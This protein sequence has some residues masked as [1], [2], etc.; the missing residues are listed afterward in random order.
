MMAQEIFRSFGGQ[1][2]LLQ[3]FPI[4]FTKIFGG[5][6][7]HD[8][9]RHIDGPASSFLLG[10]GMIESER[11]EVFFL[12]DGVVRGKL[13]VLEGGEKIDFFVEMFGLVFFFVEEFEGFGGVL[14]GKVGWFIHRLS[15]RRFYDLF[16]LYKTVMILSSIIYILLL[17]LISPYYIFCHSFYF[18]HGIPIVRNHPTSSRS[19]ASPISSHPPLLT[20]ITSASKLSFSTILPI[21]KKILP[22]NPHSPAKSFPWK[23][24]RLKA[25]RKRENAEEKRTQLE[26]RNLPPTPLFYIYRKKRTKFRQNMKG[27][28]LRP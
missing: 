15:R 20:C 11:L 9:G 28:L 12:E 27:S 22:R 25:R 10:E 21:R 16:L 24:Q 8:W 13:D 23:K 5:I 18:I 2:N 17:K 26:N 19:T 7:L 14:E 6:F 4:F 1:E 3:T